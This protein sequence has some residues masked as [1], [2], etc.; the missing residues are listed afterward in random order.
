MAT[1]IIHLL[2][3]SV[4]NQ[5]AAGEVVQRP[6]SVVKE[7]VENSLDAGAT[8]IKVIVT[9]G[10]KTQ[11]QVIDNGKGMSET[12]AR[13]SFERHATSKISS[14]EDLFSLLTM[15]FRGE[16]LASI[17]SVAQVE[18]RT[19]RSEDELGTQ[20]L[21]SGS[22][23]ELHE[24]V[25]CPVGSNFIIRNI[26]FNVPARRRFLKSDSTELSNI[27][28]EM[29]RIVLVHTDVSF[30]LISNGNEIYNL[31]RIAHKDEQ[32]ESNLSPI[33]PN[34]HRII[35]VFG[36][37]MS[38]EL[39]PVDVET[40][41]VKISGFISTPSAVRHKGVQQFFFV[42]GRYMRHP[43]FASAVTHAY[44]NIIVA[45]DRPSFFIGII[46]D[47][48]TL[49]V[50]IHPQKTEIKFEGEQA[51]WQVLS[52][53]VKESLGKFGAVP[54]IDFNVENKPDIPVLSQL[55]GD[56]Y[57]KSECEKLAS[58]DFAIHSTTYN[59]FQNNNTTPIRHPSAD[60][61]QYTLWTELEN[62]ENVEIPCFQLRQRSIVTPVL[63]GIMIIDQH[64]A[65]VAILYAQYMQWLA[66]Y[67]PVAERLLF[68]EIVQF[69]RVECV[70]L[71]DILTD[72]EHI[73]FDL[74]NLG[75][76]SYSVNAVPSG[77]HLVSPSDLLHDLVYA[78]METVTTVHDRIQSTIANTLAEHAAISAGQI[79]STR[80]M[81]TLIHD[82]MKLPT[83]RYTE[84]GQE[85]FEIIKI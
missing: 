84:S 57:K 77:L 59:P 70:T 39:L 72:L 63:D 74:S 11:I 58:H 37:K 42:N 41:M 68:P 73:G 66:T 35:D 53:T 12:D 65:H 31:P 61:Q 27:V 22:H 51:I 17:A 26:F 56:E 67:N 30:T 23:V 16:A 8:D 79:L 52:A 38:A 15:G 10:G 54:M 14:A 28:A 43:Y 34:I 6:A 78:T 21:I 82:L 45:G 49:D 50:N 5:I 19:R 85:V 13:L 48:A 1:D 40:S 2:P 7:L 18:L 69:T 60:S 76:G 55:N 62:G 75:G 20:I 44:D 25:V 64:R 24:P 32:S 33:V 3:D 4:A 81:T 46:V 9:D 47:P 29:E 36:K 80:E 83:P 71:E